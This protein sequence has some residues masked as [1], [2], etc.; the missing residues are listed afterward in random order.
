MFREAVRGTVRARR[1]SSQYSG[2]TLDLALN[3][4]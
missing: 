3:L 1:L 4:T 2:E